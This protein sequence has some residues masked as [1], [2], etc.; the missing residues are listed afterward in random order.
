LKEE[1]KVPYIWENK[2]FG[3]DFGFLKSDDEIN[4]YKPLF[5]EN[6]SIE[7]NSIDYFLCE[8]KSILS[9]DLNEINDASEIPKFIQAS[10]K[11]VRSGSMDGLCLYFRVI[12]DDEINFDTSPLH[13][14]THW[15]NVF[16]RIENK[17][18]NDGEII[19]LK[20]TM[21]D[22]IN[23]STWLLTIDE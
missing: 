8:P 19:S 23:R 14:R 16:F 13:V 4:K 12:F 20:L 17:Y 9:F 2:I 3:I 7:H 21:E 18:Y 10:K 1:Y 15:S 11:V 5:Y 6:Q 22:L